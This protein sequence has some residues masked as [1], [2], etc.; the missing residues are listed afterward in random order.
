MTRVASAQKLPIVVAERR[1]NPRNSANASA[2]P[3]AADRKLWIVR[4]NIWLK[5]D[6]VD[7]PP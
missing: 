5:F 7:S 2:M 3:V 6:M 1:A 4:P